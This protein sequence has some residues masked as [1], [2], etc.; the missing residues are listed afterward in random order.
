MTNFFQILKFYKLLFLLTLFIYADYN[1]LFSKEIILNKY[2]TFNENLM[3][4]NDE[5]SN[6]INL[7]RQIIVYNWKDSSWVFSAKWLF[8]YD[9]LGRNTDKLYLK[10]NLDDWVNAMRWSYK[11]NALG[12]LYEEISE[13]WENNSW[14]FSERITNYY[15]DNQK[16]KKRI[17]RTWV[18]NEWKYH[19]QDTFLLNNLNL[20]SEWISKIWENGQWE[21]YFKIEYTYNK[22]GNELEN[23][24][25]K[26]NNQKWEPFRKVINSYSDLNL[27]DSTLTLSF[28]DSI[29][30]NNSLEYFYYDKFFKLKE[31]YF[32]IWDKNK[33]NNVWKQFYNYNINLTINEIYLNVWKDDNW[34][35]YS[36]RVYDYS[37]E[38]TSSEQVNDNREQ[39]FSV[40]SD[41]GEIILQIF[42]DESNPATYEI[43]NL[44]GNSLINQNFEILKGFNFYKLSSD[45]LTS[46]I[47]FILIKSN[48]NTNLLKLNLIK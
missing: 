36:K 20:N 4:L 48:L 11:Y 29:W 40:N 2:N 24:Y 47:Y 32:S 15:Y 22:F 23:T 33:W 46:G 41:N 30:V 44:N 39:S 34:V 10:W 18:D 17:S 38:L 1:K 26:W 7:P 37:R 28:L 25:Y 16:L 6:N 45:N 42:S 12:L 43:F 35:F 13:R 14:V 19:A 27:K 21:N 8:N 31:W 9:S 3:E 5:D